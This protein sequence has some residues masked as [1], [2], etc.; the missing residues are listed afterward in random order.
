MLHLWSCAVPGSETILG[1]PVQLEVREAL[2][3]LVGY[4]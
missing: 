3:T 2:P 4:E 1:A